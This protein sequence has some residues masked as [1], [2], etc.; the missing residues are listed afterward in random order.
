[1][2]KRNFLLSLFLVLAGLLTTAGTASAN[3]GSIVFVKKHNVWLANAD[4]S[5]QYQVTDD[6]TYESPWGSPS[7]AND[8]TIAASH[9]DRIVR[10]RQN[11]EVLN[12]IN[13]PPLV[14]SVSHLV[15]GVPVDVAISPNGK[16]IA[17]SFVSYECP[18]G[19]S[20]GARPVTGYTAADRLTDPAIHGST[21]FSEP[22]WVGNGRTLQSG[23]YGSQI[24]IHD[25]GAGYP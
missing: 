14:N 20:C 15:D 16:L 12:T 5:G 2:S 8:G 9:L 18:I 11:G 17:W 7:Q 10:L 4:G 19:A 25:L 21:F 1:M 13:P 22:S 3:P 24:N 23:G 6:G